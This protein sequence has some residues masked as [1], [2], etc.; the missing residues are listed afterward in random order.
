MTYDS[1][2]KSAEYQS[3]IEDQ[4]AQILQAVSGAAWNFD[5]DHPRPT[6]PR[7]AFTRDT[8]RIGGGG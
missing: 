7:T 1:G 6:A 2:L 5:A 3:W 8:A 4:T